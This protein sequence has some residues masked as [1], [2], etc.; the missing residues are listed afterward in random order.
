ML[1]FADTAFQIFMAI[2]AFSLG[3]FFA[4]VQ[5]QFFR[6]PLRLSIILYLWHTVFSMYYM[7]YS[8]D[9]A[10]D[11]ISYYRR[12]I[13]YSDGFQFGTKGV[14]YITSFF[15]DILG[16][17]YGGTFLIFNL[18]GVVGLLAVAG[19]LLEIIPER[20]TLARRL[21]MIVLFLPG[22]SFWS[23]AIGKDSLAFMA[24]G[25]TVWASLRLKT[26]YLA[27][28][29]AIATFFLARP[30]IGALVLVALA[31]AMAFTLRVGL[32]KRLAMLAVVLPMAAAGIVFGLQFAG[33]EEASEVSNISEYIE[34]RQTYNMSGG[35][36][37]DISS[38]SWPARIFAYLFRPLPL[39]SGGIMG[40]I[41]G[42]ENLFLLIF[43]LIFTLRLCRGKSR[44]VLFTR[45]FMLL[46][47]A[48][49]LV[50]L[51]NTTANLGISI[52][53]KW[54]LMPML[55]CVVISYAKI[56][57][58]GNPTMPPQESIKSGYP[59]K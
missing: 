17:S 10:A 48:G 8:F 2:V 42:I 15:T 45:T 19:A 3:L 54:M 30:H 24:T 14:Y 33:I 12:S 22:V 41:V 5:K 26:R 37:I 28:L 43:F 44:L 31:L 38:M 57:R 52:R 46:Y 27:L 29:F 1:S 47:A 23:A 58:R 18:F 55:I 34:K 39:E 36:S 4:V 56:P 59:R 40:F 7:I 21:A 50:I 20:R 32:F 25:L 11:S 13:A 9:N 49:A 6:V 16:M 51:A 35:T 53:Q